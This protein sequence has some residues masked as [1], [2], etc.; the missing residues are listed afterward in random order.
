MANGLDQLPVLGEDIERPEEQAAAQYQ[1]AAIGAQNASMMPTSGG[2]SAMKSPTTMGMPKTEWLARGGLGNT[3]M[4]AVKMWKNG[5]ALSKQKTAYQ[6]LQKAGFTGARKLYNDAIARYPK[7]EI[8][9]EGIAGW[10]PRPE[11]FLTKDGEFDGQKYHQA[12]QLGLYNYKKNQIQMAKDNLAEDREK[13]LTDKQAGVYSEEEQ[14]VISEWKA[15]VDANPDATDVEASKVWSDINA[16]A[17]TRMQM[18]SEVYGKGGIAGLPTRSQRE[19]SELRKQLQADR[20]AAYKARD[21]A[22]GSKTPDEKAAALRM[23]ISTRSTLAGRVSQLESEISKATKSIASEKENKS[24]YP[25]YFSQEK[26]DR[27]EAYEESVQKELDDIRKEIKGTQ[28]LA[29]KI[30]KDLAKAGYR[31][32]EESDEPEL[33]ALSPPGADAGATVEQPGRAAKKDWKVRARELKDIGNS[34]EEI[35][36]Q[37]ELEGY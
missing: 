14:K 25:D 15:W 29:Q 34:N 10:V 12:F 11:F 16:K 13:R 17:G 21:F 22:H 3:I 9:P 30:R 35:K 18:P 2:P 27:A 32:G 23:L 1:E 31:F 5:T 37:L 20:L 7:S 24:L 6:G 28:V 26:L 8:D 33:P 36:R 19:S 4:D